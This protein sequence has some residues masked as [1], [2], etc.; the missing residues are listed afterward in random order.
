MGIDLAAHAG[1]IVY[2]GRAGKVTKLGYPYDDDADHDGKPDYEYVEVTDAAT[3]LKFRYFYVEPLVE[4][5]DLVT[6]DVPIGRVQDLQAKY[7]GITNHVHFEVM[8]GSQ[9]LDPTPY[10]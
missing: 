9:K 6:P 3:G 8:D 10:L 7:P 2:P 5:G 1:A 4:V